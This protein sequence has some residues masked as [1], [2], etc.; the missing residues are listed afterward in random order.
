MITLESLNNEQ[1]LVASP[2]RSANWRTN[3]WLIAG[4]G[5]WCGLIALGF[6]AL[7]LWPI[8]PFMGL[9]VVAVAAGL[10]AVCWKLEQRHVLRFRADTLVIEKGAYHPRLSWR[11]PR[12]ATFISVEVQ[13]HA[14]DPLKIFLCSRN[15]QIAI[16]NFLNHDES[17]ELLRQLRAQGLAVRNYSESTRTAI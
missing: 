3:K 16:G 5:T 2:N 17:E 7:G 8:A 11:W 4:F 6:L 15:E 9:E 14:W 1:M 10:Y 13:P 12:S